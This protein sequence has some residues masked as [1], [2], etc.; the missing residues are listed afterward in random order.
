MELN[1]ELKFQLTFSDKQ[2]INHKK[3]YHKFDEKPFSCYAQT[4]KL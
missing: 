3:N 1:I 2:W 4:D